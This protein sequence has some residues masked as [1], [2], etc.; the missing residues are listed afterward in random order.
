LKQSC[1][2]PR[3]CFLCKKIEK[4]E[5]ISPKA[6]KIPPYL[7]IINR[8]EDTEREKLESKNN[9]KRKVKAKGEIK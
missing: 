1:G 8:E 2:H 5:I 7:L 9:K 4:F 6:R 3:L